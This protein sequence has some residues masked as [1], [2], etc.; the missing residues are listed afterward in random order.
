[1]QSSILIAQ[2]S[3]DVIDCGYKCIH[4]MYVPNVC[5]Q[6]ADRSECVEIYR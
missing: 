1:M 4:V 6:T 2:K 3:L 5:I